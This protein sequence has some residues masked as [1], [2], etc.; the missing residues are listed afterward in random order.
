MAEPGPSTATTNSSAA[1]RGLLRSHRLGLRGLVVVL[2]AVAIWVSLSLGVLLPVLGSVFSGPDLRLLISVVAALLLLLIPTAGIY[3]LIGQYAFWEGWL[4][5]LPRPADLFR[6][7]PSPPSAAPTRFLVYLDG[8]HQVERDHPP[9]VLRLLEEIERGLDPGTVLLKGMESYTVLPVKLADDRGSA[10]LWRRLFALQEEHPLA[11]IR[12]LAAFLVQANNVI[13]V[14]ISSDR[15][16]GPIANYLLALKIV[17]SLLPLGFVIGQQQQLVLLGYSGGGEMAMG[18]ADYLHQLSRSPIRILAFCG[19]FSGNQQLEHVES[20]EMV[21]G[22]RD[23]VAAFGRLAYP[24]RLDLLPLSRWN[25]AR[26]RGQVSQRMLRGM[27]HNGEYGPFSDR[28]RSS[29]ARCLLDL[30]SRPA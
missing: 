23:P 28:F 21:V 1:F 19:V 8:I 4:T 25:Q 27:G 20:I 5:G 26:R 14:G 6:S 30:L 2:L 7:A 29:L 9:R 12:F 11:W 24:G 15:R 18:V 3:S 10:W 13:K 17:H 22:S 16:Y